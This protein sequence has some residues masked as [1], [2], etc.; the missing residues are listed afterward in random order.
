VVAKLSVPSG[1]ES[2]LTRGMIS[3]IHALTLALAHPQ[4]HLFVEQLP[5][6]HRRGCTAVDPT[7][8]IVPPRREVEIA[9]WRTEVRS[10]PTFSI[11]LVAIAA[12]VREASVWIAS[13]TGALGF[14]SDCINDGIG[15]ASLGHV[16]D[17]E[18]WIGVVAPFDDYGAADARAASAPERDRPR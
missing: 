2:S 11:S 9:A 13:C 7:I 6:R 10:L 18:R 8:E 4:L 17:L 1:S 3:S 16:D 15:A 12:G 5:H 14:C